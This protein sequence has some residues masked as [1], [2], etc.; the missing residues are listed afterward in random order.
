MRDRVE[1]MINV[2]Q[3]QFRTAADP[4]TVLT[5]ILGSCVACCL[6]DPVRR[7]G[8]MNHFLL[9]GSD[10]RDGRCVRYG[11]HAMEQL[12]NELLRTGAVRDRLQ[13]HI[14]GGANVVPGLGRIGS[15]NARFAR[16]FIRREGFRLIGSH[17]GGTR[18]YRIRFGAG[19]GE[20]QVERLAHSDRSLPQAR[21]GGPTMSLPRGRV[22]LF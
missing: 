5:T 15:G 11:A 13:A 20:L 12:I 2:G 22:D 7:V 4:G 6:H 18:G 8:G 10:P 9:P 19:T 1:T 21:D 16:G 14:V 17:T 3:G